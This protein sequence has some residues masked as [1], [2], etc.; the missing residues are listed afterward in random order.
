MANLNTKPQTNLLYHHP[1]SITRV[2]FPP[3]S[4]LVWRQWTSGVEQGELMEDS[5]ATAAVGPSA[6]L[7]AR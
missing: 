7:E 2:V 4:M 1:A 6:L 5:V 3:A